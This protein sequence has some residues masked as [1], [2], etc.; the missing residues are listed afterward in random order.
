MTEEGQPFPPRMFKKPLLRSLIL[1]LALLF[2]LF[3]AFISVVPLNRVSLGTRP[4]YGATPAAVLH[5]AHLHTLAHLLVYGL[6]ACVA[7]LASDLAEARV[8]GKLIALTLTL[9][10]GWSTEYM[11]ARLYHNPI[12]I[13][14]IAANLLAGAFVFGLLAVLRRI[15]PG[16]PST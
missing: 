8:T 4:G 12:E 16:H 14:D 6:V 2:G 1:L 15:I 10:L 11:Q 9:L 7:W 3:V 5:A 13:M